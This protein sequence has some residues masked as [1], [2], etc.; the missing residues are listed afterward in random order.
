MTAGE[1]WRSTNPLTMARIARGH[2]REQ[3]AS[4]TSTS[5]R[6]VTTAEMGNTR[7][8]P[9]LH[10]MTR[11]GEYLGIPCLRFHELWVA[12]M[13]RRPTDMWEMVE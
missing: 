4:V 10:L 1:R 11:F 6:D 5:L 7:G 9:S 2:T 8:G 13:Q 3:C 12:W